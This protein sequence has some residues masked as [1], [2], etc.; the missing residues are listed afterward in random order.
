MPL[1]QQRSGPLLHAVPSVP[2]E[3]PLYGDG[4]PMVPFVQADPPEEQKQRSGGQQEQYHLPGFIPIGDRRRQQRAPPLPLVRQ[5]EQQKM[6]RVSSP[7]KPA[8]QTKPREPQAAPPAPSTGLRDADISTLSIKGG[9]GFRFSLRWLTWGD[10][11]V[12][13]SML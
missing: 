12:Q 1:L 6:E 2:E 5:H 3:L 13:V 4:R 9:H 10:T 7:L 11:A 8:W